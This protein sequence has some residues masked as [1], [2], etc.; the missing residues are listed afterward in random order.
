[1]HFSHVS[2]FSSDLRP[3]HPVSSQGGLEIIENP[4]KAPTETTSESLGKPPIFS[5]PPVLPVG[6]SPPCDL[7]NLWDSNDTISAAAFIWHSYGS[8]GA[9]WRQDGK[10]GDAPQELRVGEGWSVLVQSTSPLWPA[11]PHSPPGGFPLHTPTF[12]TAVSDLERSPTGSPPHHP[13]C[14]PEDNLSQTIWDGEGNEHPVAAGSKAR[15]LVPV[16]PPSLT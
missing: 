8:Q 6:Y 16:G 3:D 10:A 9:W 14:S 11:W 5:G 13:P 2:I 15:P 4:T 7:E 12:Q 1:M